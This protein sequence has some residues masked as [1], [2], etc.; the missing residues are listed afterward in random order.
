MYS[1]SAFTQLSWR[2]S[3]LLY[4]YY[5]SHYPLELYF[6]N[7]LQNGTQIIPSKCYAMLLIDLANP[8]LIKVDCS[9]P[10]TANILCQFESKIMT[11]KK[12]L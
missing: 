4:G 8:K 5:G 3:R 1:A 6:F 9:E 10:I 11:L 7:K 12:T 2:K